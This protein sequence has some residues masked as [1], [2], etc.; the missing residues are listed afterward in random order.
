MVVVPQGA[1]AEFGRSSGG[2]VNVITKSGTN[3]LHGSVHFFGKNDALSGTARHEGLE[4]APDF[5]Q[6]QFGFTMGGPLIKDR[7]FFFT[8]YDQQ[9]FKD[10]KQND[11]ERIDPRLRAFMDEQFSGALAGDYGPIDRTNDAR[12]FLA[13]IDARLSDEHYATFKY[14]YT[15]SEQENGTFDVDSWARSANAVEQ[16]W[17]PRLQRQPAIAAV[18]DHHQRVPLPGFPRGSPAALHWPEQSQHRPPLPRYRH[19]LCP[20]LSLWHALLHSGRVLRHPHP[21][22]R[23]HLRIQGQSLDQSRSRVEPRRI[24]ADLHRLCQWPLHLQLARWL[25]QLRRARQRLCR[26]RRRQHQHHRGLPRRDGYHRTG[27][28]LFAAVRRRR[29]DR[30]RSGHP[31]DPAARIGPVCA[32]QLAALKQ[33]DAQLRPALGSA[34]SA[35]CAHRSRRG[36]LRRFHRQNR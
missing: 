4:R 35:R 28:A 20:R 16:D 34:N 26:V 18:R 30:G 11:S 5:S 7:V 10:T 29:P 31:A 3:Q 24:R 33:A 27:F 22:T 23:Q 2:F 6:G 25:P 19:G 15:W 17:S 14:N 32:G 9:V 12:A 8:A 36:I 1:N 13:K 21:S